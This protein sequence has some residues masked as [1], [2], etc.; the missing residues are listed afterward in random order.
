[1]DV[2]KARSQPSQ[3]SGIC[4]PQLT[5]Q[6]LL[7]RILK[8]L[9][10]TTNITALA[11]AL[12]PTTTMTHAT[13]PSRLTSILQKDHFPE[14]TNPTN[15]KMSRTLPPSWK[16]IFLSLSSIVGSPAGANR[17]RTQ[18]S[19]STIIRPP[20]TD[21]LRRKK[22]RSKIR[23]YP[24][25]CVMTTP[26]SPA[27]AYSECLR[28]MTSVEQMIM[29][30]TLTMRKRCVIP[31]GTIQR[32]VSNSAMTMPGEGAASHTVPEVVQIQQLIIPLCQDPERVF[33]KGNH[34]QKP[35]D[36]G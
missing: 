35:S 9:S 24:S 2:T 15:K 36:G 14:K 13:K 26:Q 22:F 27:T 30:I 33:E 17:F 3:S 18:L 10:T 12:N 29:A 8:M 11:F 23:P 21:K 1:V 28:M 31:P 5:V 16:Y 34:N 20:N 25:A 19:E 7:T 6:K 32:R 4:S